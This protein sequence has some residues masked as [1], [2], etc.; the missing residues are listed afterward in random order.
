MKYATIIA[1]L[2]A[3]SARVNATHVVNAI[4]TN[5]ISAEIQG[6]NGAEIPN[7]FREN[8]YLPKLQMELV[9]NTNQELN[10]EMEEGFLMEPTEKGYQVLLMTQPLIVKLKPKSKEKQFIYAMCA[11]LSMSSPSSKIKYKV[12]KKSSGALLELAQ[13]IAK[14]RCQ[15]FAAQEAVWSLTDNSP[16]LSIHSENLNIQN[17]LQAFVANLKGVNL[18]QLKKENAYNN[19]AQIMAVYNGKQFDRNIVFNTDTAHI[20]SVGYYS[21]SGELLKPIIEDVLVKDGA[22]SIRYNPF[23]LSLTNKRYSVRMIK[24]GE[25]FREYYFMQ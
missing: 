18:E 21:Q 3:F 14:N 4:A 15:S 10:L 22:H 13:Y 12:G 17:G 16:I 7:N 11:Q 1:M 6:A 25:I 19:L 23:P 2:I 9:N 8:N 24:D 20:I 5:L